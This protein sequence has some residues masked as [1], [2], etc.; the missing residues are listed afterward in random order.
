[1]ALFCSVLVFVFLV[2]H[3]QYTRYALGVGAAQEK[4]TCSSQL[5][6]TYENHP[7]FQMLPTMGVVFVDLMKFGSLPVRSREVDLLD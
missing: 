3:S 5:R 2:S 6:F 1:M 7:E 4:P